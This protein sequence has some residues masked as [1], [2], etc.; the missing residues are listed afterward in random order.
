MES[1]HG[2][3]RR[4]FALNAQ[5]LGSGPQHC[6]SKRTKVLLLWEYCPFSSPTPI[7]PQEVPETEF[8]QQNTANSTGSTTISLTQL[9]ETVAAVCPGAPRTAWGHSVTPVD[10]VSVTL[11]EL[12]PC[13]PISTRKPWSARLHWSEKKMC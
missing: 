12:A 4:V 6:R 13:S 1:V 7:R 11:A 10:T 2:L 9:G 8:T 3:S 5:G